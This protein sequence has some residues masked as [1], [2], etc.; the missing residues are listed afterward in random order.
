M[1]TME[2]AACRGHCTGHATLPHSH[3]PS[4]LCFPFPRAGGRCYMCPEGTRCT[5]TDD[6]EKSPCTPELPPEPCPGAYSDFE[7]IDSHRYCLVSF[8][9]PRL[10][11]LHVRDSGWPILCSGSGAVC[12]WHGGP[13]LALNHPK[14]NPTSTFCTRRTMPSSSAPTT[15][16]A[17]ATR[18]RRRASLRNPRNQPAPATTLSATTRSEGVGELELWFVLGAAQEGRGS[19]AGRAVWHQTRL[20][21]FFKPTT[22]YH[23]A[24]RVTSPNPDQPTAMK[25]T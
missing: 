1:F 12:V 15:A 8:W 14:L 13:R 23:H 3:P 11:W 24:V 22:S 20:P 10:G 5:G 17:M 18:T 16:G 7:C 2:L 6:P 21:T 9:I 25:L 19:A 4:T